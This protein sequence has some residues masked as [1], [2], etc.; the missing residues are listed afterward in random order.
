MRMLRG[1]AAACMQAL[2]GEEAN[3]VL[4]PCWDETEHDT[5]LE[6]LVDSLLSIMG[7]LGASDDLRLHTKAVQAA[8]EAAV[9]SA[10]PVAAAVPNPE[11]ID[12]TGDEDEDVDM[13]EEGGEVTVAEHVLQPAH[14]GQHPSFVLA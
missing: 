6:A 14:A 1:A 12:L 5:V 8:L 7:P 2:P 10:M 9:Q 11:E 3:M 4:V 13:A